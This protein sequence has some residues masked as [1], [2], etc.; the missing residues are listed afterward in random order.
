MRTHI[1]IGVQLLFLLFGIVSSNA[2]ERGHLRQIWKLRLKEVIQSANVHEPLAV[3]GLSF[4][5]DGQR[6]AAVVGSTWKEENVI[7]LR[8]ADPKTDVQR[9]GVNPQYYE[10]EVVSSRSILWP[11]PGHMILDRSLLNLSNGTLCTLPFTGY[12]LFSVPDQ[13][14]GSDL[15]VYDWNCQVRRQIDHQATW[16]LVDVSAERSLLCFYQFVTRG[17]MLVRVDSFVV[18]ANSQKILFMVPTTRAIGVKF[19]ANG[20]TICGMQ[21]REWRDSVSCWDI[22]TG[23]EVSSSGRPTHLFIQPAINAPRIVLSDYGRK[24][25]FIDI[26][27]TIGSL[28]RRIIWDYRTGQEIVSWKP[29]FQDAI[30]GD[31]PAA[32]YRRSYRFAISP[33]GEYIIEGG[34]EN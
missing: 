6:I 27:W 33:D 17:A 9:L 3:F 14:I 21:G 25:D 19:A 15:K 1:K 32:V 12:N 5:P 20:K 29:K 23:K 28:R 11:T 31:N 24:I 26:R 16:R 4:S 22:D 30:T 8:T 10:S 18:D 34:R 2:G 13:I 7:I